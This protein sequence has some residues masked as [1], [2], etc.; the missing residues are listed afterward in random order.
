M[1]TIPEV[2]PCLSRRRYQRVTAAIYH[3][4]AEFPMHD[5]SHYRPP[6]YAAVP[7]GGASGIFEH[8]Y[9]VFIMAQRNA[10]RRLDEH[11]MSALIF[12]SR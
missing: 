8:K 11:E 3:A 12:F 2:E 5:S 9:R 10:M 7:I 4:Y 6:L 1:T